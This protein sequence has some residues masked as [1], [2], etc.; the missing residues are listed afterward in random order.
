LGSEFPR[1]KAIGMPM[2]GDMKRRRVSWWVVV[3][4]VAAVLSVAGC[5]FKRKLVA[6]TVLP[7]GATL[8]GPGLQIQ[9][10]A[11]GSY[12]HPPDSRD[13]TNSVAWESAAPQVISIDET[14]LATSGVDCGQ[15]ITI[16]A[17]GHSDPGDQ[18]S[19]LVIGKATV[20]VCQG[21]AA[22]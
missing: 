22:N 19:G 15:N 13:I 5:G 16:T 2:K 7:D 20:N 3:L 14:G 4:T 1:E 17:S 12:I 10:K 8:G 11:V 21:G 18:S 9:F 6:I